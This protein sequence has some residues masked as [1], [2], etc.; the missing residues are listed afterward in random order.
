MGNQACNP[1]NPLP[2]HSMSTQGH[3]SKYG[4]DHSSAAQG[5]NENNERIGKIG[6]D[7]SFKSFPWARNN[8]CYS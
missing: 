2:N 6:R 1:V 7:S 4:N 3:L 5:T 8:C